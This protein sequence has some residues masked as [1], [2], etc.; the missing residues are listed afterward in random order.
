MRFVDRTLQYVGAPYCGQ[1][2]SKE[3]GYDCFSLIVNFL[4]ESGINLPEDYQWKGLTFQSYYDLWKEDKDNA[5]QVMTKFLEEHTKRK[6]LKDLTVGDILIV[7]SNDSNTTFCAI[8]GGNDKIITADMRLGV[9][10][11]PLRHYNIN[12]IFEG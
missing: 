11:L 8:Y 12:D 7:T 3:E 1:G 9:L 2:F 6:L 5:V 4:R 10:G